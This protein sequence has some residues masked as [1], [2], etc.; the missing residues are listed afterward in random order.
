MGAFN[1][2]ILNYSAIRNRLK[3]EESLTVIRII[4]LRMEGGV[5]FINII[6]FGATKSSNGLHYSNG[7]GYRVEFLYNCSSKKFE[8]R[9]VKKGSV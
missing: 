8:L 9:A 1:V 7:G 5:F 4:P 6:P 3:K 2:E